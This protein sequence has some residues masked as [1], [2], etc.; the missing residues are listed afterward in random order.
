[1]VYFYASICDKEGVFVGLMLCKT[2]LVNGNGPVVFSVNILITQRDNGISN[3]LLHIEPCFLTINCLG[4]QQTCNVLAL[5]ESAEGKKLPAQFLH[6][7]VI[8][9]DCRN[10]INYKTAGSGFAY[11]FFKK[12]LQVL[13]AHHTQLQFRAHVNV[14]SNFPEVQQMNFA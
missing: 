11:V 9:D 10:R 2:H 1:M 8:K 3:K 5:Q 12:I 6:I 4:Y 13:E 7:A 14:S